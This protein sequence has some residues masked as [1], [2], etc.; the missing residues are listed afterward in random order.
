MLFGT[1]A[2][3]ALPLDLDQHT[4]AVIAASVSATAAYEQG[5]IEGEQSADPH[6]H[7]P[8]D[9][10]APALI[11]EAREV[12]LAF[13]TDEADLSAA[14]QRQLREVLAWHSAVLATATVEVTGFAS[15]LGSV[16][17]NQELA[18]RR[19]SN[20]MHAIVGALPALADRISGFSRGEG[21]AEAAGVAD[22]DNDQEWR[23]VE[24]SIAGQV[25]LRLYAEVPMTIADAGTIPAQ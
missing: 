22:G 13:A 16:E 10:R 5:Q 12:R 17:H 8:T 6:A 23:K 2:F 15:R 7:I 4:T 24:V 9:E 20:T 19:T 1:C 3:P 21:A 18:D 11:A 14:A 25:V